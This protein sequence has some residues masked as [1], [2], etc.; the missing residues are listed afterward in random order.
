[1]TTNVNKSKVRLFRIQLILWQGF[2]LIYTKV[3]VGLTC[4]YI[5]T[6]KKPENNDEKTILN[7]TENLDW[8]EVSSYLFLKGLEK[9]MNETKEER[10]GNILM[11][12]L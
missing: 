10:E 11:F 2:T 7:E 1:M 12:L 5:Q 6:E 4:L 3:Q 9:K 8:D